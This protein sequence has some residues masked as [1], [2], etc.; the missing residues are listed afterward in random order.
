LFFNL[1]WTQFFGPE[2]TVGEN[3]YDFSMYF[4]FFNLK[5]VIVTH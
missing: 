2:L 4:L 3:G 5:T 1:L